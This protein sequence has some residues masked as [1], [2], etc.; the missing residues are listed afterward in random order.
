M[1]HEP[2][3]PGYVIAAS[4]SAPFPGWYLKSVGSVDAYWTPA[5]AEAM[6]FTSPAAA[7]GYWNSVPPG[8]GA[9]FPVEVRRA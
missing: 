6:R 2:P 3:A 4:Q 9:F 7:M 5:Q 1:G 8:L